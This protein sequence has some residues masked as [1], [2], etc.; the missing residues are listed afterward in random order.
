[1]PIAHDLVQAE[2][3]MFSFQ[4]PAALNRPHQHRTALCINYTIDVG[5]SSEL[6]C[7]FNMMREKKL[8][9]TITGSS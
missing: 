4:P 6:S 3:S 8:C 7:E 1:M 2:R 9:L 5:F